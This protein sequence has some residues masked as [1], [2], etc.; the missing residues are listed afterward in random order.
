MA[1]EVNSRGFKEGFFADGCYQ[2]VE[3]RSA[4]GI[5]DAVKVGLGCANVGNVSNDRVSCRHEVLLVGPDFATCSKCGPLPRVHGC[6]ACCQ[7]T[8]ILGE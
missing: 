2:L 7:G 1:L 3:Y 8:L 4:F 5:G 6:S